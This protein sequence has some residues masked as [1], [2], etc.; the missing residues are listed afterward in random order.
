MKK[1]HLTQ[2]QRYEIQA[3]LKMGVKQAEIARQIG[4]NRSV[5]SHEIRYNS[6]LNGR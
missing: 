4:K 5:I 3:Y 1:L 2:D 6:E